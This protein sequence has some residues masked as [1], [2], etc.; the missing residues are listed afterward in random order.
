[1]ES[2][3]P[4]SQPLLLMSLVVVCKDGTPAF[5]GDEGYGPID[6]AYLFNPRSPLPCDEYRAPVE[7]CIAKAMCQNARCR[8]GL[9]LDGVCSVRALLLS[10]PHDS[11]MALHQC[12]LLLDTVIARLKEDGYASNDSP[13][14]RLSDAG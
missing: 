9:A 8:R 5:W 6:R 13:S 2:H 4:D 7:L 14:G 1:M 3:P 10:I 11:T 12:A